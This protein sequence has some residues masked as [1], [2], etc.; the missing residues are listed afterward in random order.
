MLA[1]LE[2]ERE[3]EDPHLGG[4][5]FE[6]R[7]RDFG[8]VEAADLE[9]LE[10][11]PLAPELLGW[12]DLESHRTFRKDVDALGHVLHGE[13]NR[14]ADIEAVTEAQHPGALVVC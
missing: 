3:S 7:G 8:Q 4:E 1:I 14:V 9:E 6:H 13:M 5:R 2:Q 12:V 11:F 10:A